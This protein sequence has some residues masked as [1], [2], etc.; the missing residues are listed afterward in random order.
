MSVG[1]SQCYDINGRICCRPGNFLKYKST[2][3][4]RRKNV[5]MN[6]NVPK[7]VPK[8]EWNCASLPSSHFPTWELR[9][10]YEILRYGSII[11]LLTGGPL[12]ERK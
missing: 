6:E 11:K 3:T 10:D 7:I 1:A 2:V 5:F 12:H 9:L 4:R 8:G